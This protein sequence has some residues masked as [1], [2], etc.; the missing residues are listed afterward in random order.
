MRLQDELTQMR[1]PSTLQLGPATPDLDTEPD[2]ELNTDL[3]ETSQPH[4]ATELDQTKLKEAVIQHPFSLLISPLPQFTGQLPDALPLPSDDEDREIQS[5][6]DQTMAVSVHQDR[7]P[8]PL[9]SEVSSTL[10]TEC[11]AP[12]RHLSTSNCE[13]VGFLANSINEKPRSAVTNSVPTPVLPAKARSSH[14][15][16]LPDTPLSS[17][18]SRSQT[19]SA[20]L[21]SPSSGPSLKSSGNARDV[22][23]PVPGQSSLRNREPELLKSRLRDLL[24]DEP[25]TSTSLLNVSSNHFP[26]SLTKEI[27]QQDSRQEALRVDSDYGNMRPQTR[28]NSI[29]SPKQSEE[30]TRVSPPAVIG[31]AAPAAPSV[32]PTHSAPVISRA[33]NAAMAMER[34]RKEK[35]EQERERRRTEKRLAESESLGRSSSTSTSGISSTRINAREAHNSRTPA[36]Y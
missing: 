11:N 9:Q 33:S 27:P 30:C 32:H 6:V 31:Y 36:P 20:S 18:R 14:T 21:S 1:A 23:S 3:W 24:Q 34:E 28:M 16:G 15:A 35:K 19:I 22:Y 12:N 29:V 2:P 13:K 26:S 4:F 25:S 10:L 5:G 17:G 7:S 8:T